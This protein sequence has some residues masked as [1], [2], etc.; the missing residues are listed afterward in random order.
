MQIKDRPLFNTFNVY[1][2]DICL[3]FN[4]ANKRERKK[5]YLRRFIERDYL[6]FM[7]NLPP[8]CI[9]KLALFA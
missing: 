4:Y 7:H 1:L 8:N 5:K 2:I 9:D 6:H 3:I